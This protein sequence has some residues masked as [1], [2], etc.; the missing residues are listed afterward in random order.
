[1]QLEALKAQMRDA[2]AQHDADIE[3]AKNPLHTRI[4]ELEDMAGGAKRV[5]SM[6]RAARK[7]ASKADGQVQVCILVLGITFHNL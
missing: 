3:A 1:M 4:K 2:A 7:A 5:E 6:L